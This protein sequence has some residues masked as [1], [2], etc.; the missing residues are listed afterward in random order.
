MIDFFK[1]FQQQEHA[2]LTITGEGDAKALTERYGAQVDRMWN[3]GDT[4]LGSYHFDQMCLYVRSGMRDDDASEQHIESIVHCYEGRQLHTLPDEL[5][6][7]VHVVTHS[8]HSQAG[9]LWLNADL[10]R[11]L[12]WIKARV[13]I[14]VYKM[15]AHGE[16]LLEHHHDFPGA[17]WVPETRTQDK[18]AGQYAHLELRSYDTT[19]DEISQRLGLTPTKS[20]Q[21]GEAIVRGEQPT[22]AHNLWKMASGVDSQQ[23]MAAH[24]DA[25]NTVLVA[26][27]DVLSHFSANYRNEIGI[28]AAAHLDTSICIT[29]PAKLIE[30]MAMLGMSFELDLYLR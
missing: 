30:R 29:L 25:L 26:K 19:A 20:W 15:V 7:T 23:E 18:N 16:R 24:L 17:R 2:Y 11:R 10:I 6:R 27:Q 3:A 21:R 9:G 28:A 14:H 4:E 5:C 22:R 8:A 1:H 13:C 12:A